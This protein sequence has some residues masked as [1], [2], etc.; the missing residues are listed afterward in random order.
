MVGSLPFKEKVPDMK[1]LRTSFPKEDVLKNKFIES[2]SVEAY[3]LGNLKYYFKERFIGYL[4]TDPA[5]RAE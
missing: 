1:L 5:D 3:L 4:E 2:D